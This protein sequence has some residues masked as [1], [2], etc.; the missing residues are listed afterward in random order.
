MLWF[1]VCRCTSCEDSVSVPRGHPK[2]NASLMDLQNTCKQSVLLPG[3]GDGCYHLMPPQA[4]L[5][6]WMYCPARR[7][8]SRARCVPRGQTKA[9]WFCEWPLSK[10][11]CP[12][13]AGSFAERRDCIKAAVL[14]LQT[15]GPR[16][17]K[18][19]S[20]RSSA[21]RFPN[22]QMCSC[23][24]ASLWPLDGNRGP[25]GED[26]RARP[27]FAPGDGTGDAREAKKMSV[28]SF[29]SV[30]RTCFVTVCFFKK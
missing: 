21:C 9:L 14:T 4:S 29:R 7:P 8:W 15:P 2:Q 13:R 20:E 6:G 16:S 22:S 10:L 18:G 11:P 17:V 24:N 23:G 28:P 27:G 26:G 12:R 5:L 30:V 1:R 19:C 25:A 3:W